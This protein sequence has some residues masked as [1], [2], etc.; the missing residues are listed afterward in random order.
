[1][2]RQAGVLAS[3]HEWDRLFEAIEAG[4]R[5]SAYERSYRRLRSECGCRM[6]GACGILATAAF[7]AAVACGITPHES[8]Q[9]VL[10]TLALTPV[11][12]IAAGVLG[13]LLGI[14]SARYRLRKLRSELLA[15]VRGA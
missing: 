10:G 14:A 15:C 9:E 6:A 4:P 2:S 1:M 8:A 3:T 11:V 12:M 5:R 7:L 13:K